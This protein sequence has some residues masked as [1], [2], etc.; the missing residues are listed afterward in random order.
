[1]TL[2]TSCLDMLVSILN[3][4]PTK[5][6]LEFHSTCLTDK[7]KHKE[8]ATSRNLVGNLSG[9]VRRKPKGTRIIAEIE[10]VSGN[11]DKA[12][13]K[14]SRRAMADKNAM[15]N[16]QTPRP[17]RSRKGEPITHRSVELE[18]DLL[19]AETTR[20]SQN[21]NT[22]GNTSSTRT[23]DVPTTTAW[24]S[25]RT[26]N[27]ERR[28]VAMSEKKVTSS[29]IR[30]AAKSTNGASPPNPSRE[31]LLISLGGGITAPQWKGLAFR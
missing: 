8:A 9:V 16:K 7:T 23:A 2:S 1:M 12:K 31:S 15:E 22:K 6:F 30:V 17:S 28:K 18:E 14:S 27:G 4:S 5:L 11:A 25:A 10:I 24:A 29:Q 3:K 13:N 21:T 20:I 19:L 26:S